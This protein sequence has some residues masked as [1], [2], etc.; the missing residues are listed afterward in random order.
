MEK[1][2][3]AALRQF[4]LPPFG[5]QAKS[6]YYVVLLNPL[7]YPA[8]SENTFSKRSAKTRSVI[9]LLSLSIVEVL[10]R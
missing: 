4:P 10:Q 9:W 8:V 3:S 2:L 6:F 1:S 5:S 7:L